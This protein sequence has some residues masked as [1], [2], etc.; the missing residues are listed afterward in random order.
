MRSGR[1]DDIAVVVQL[2]LRESAIGLMKRTNLGVVTTTTSAS[3]L[4]ST[5]RSR[6]GSL[7]VVLLPTDHDESFVPLDRLRRRFRDM[8]RLCLLRRSCWRRVFLVVP[9]TPNMRHPLQYCDVY[10]FFRFVVC[11]LVT[12]RTSRCTGLAASSPFLLISIGRCPNPGCGARRSW[13][14]LPDD[15]PIDRAEIDLIPH[16]IVLSCRL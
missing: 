12:S 10:I 16:G 2:E 14:R 9:R 13:T 5:Q 7:L 6:H 15:L 3:A 11:V 1:L 4:L 8:R